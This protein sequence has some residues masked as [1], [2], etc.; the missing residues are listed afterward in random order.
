MFRFPGHGAVS[1]IDGVGCESIVCSENGTVL[2]S[3]IHRFPTGIQSYS[4]KNVFRPE[5][6][7]VVNDG[8]ILVI[9]TTRGGTAVVHHQEIGDNPHRFL[10]LQKSSKFPV[11]R[12][13]GGVRTEEQD[14]KQRGKSRGG[15]ITGH[16]GPDDVQHG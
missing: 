6:L 15:D 2:Q 12:F 5:T 4:V 7:I 1:N 16:R 11:E 10:V 14:E 9:Q 3:S 13:L 8:S